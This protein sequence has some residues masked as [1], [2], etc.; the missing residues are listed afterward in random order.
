[1]CACV[2]AFYIYMCV[3]VK[4]SILYIEL[5]LQFS[6]SLTTIEKTTYELKSN[7]TNYNKSCIAKL[8]TNKKIKLLQ[9]LYNK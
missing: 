6:F 9:Q 2:C 4:Y 3:E 8:Q 1:M 7:K 5:K